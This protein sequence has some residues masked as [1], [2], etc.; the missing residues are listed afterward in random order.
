[1][2]ITRPNIFFLCMH[3]AASTF[4]ADVLLNSI[5]RRTASYDLFHVG[6]FLIR[7]VKRQQEES[8]MI[9][10]RNPEER[11]QQL[12]MFLEDQPLPESNGL[13]GRLYPGHMPTIDKFVSDGIP[14][15]G[16]KLMIMRRDPRDALV[17]LYYSMSISHNPDEVEGDNKAFL[18]NRQTLQHQDVRDGLKTLLTKR[19]IDSTTPEFL[20]CTDLILSNDFVVDLPYEMLINDPYMWLARFVEGADIEDIVDDEWMEQ[21]VGNLQPPAKEDPTSHKRRMRPGN[22]ADV[23][24]E[25]LKQIVNDKLGNRL[26]QFGYKW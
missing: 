11:R 5:A 2:V 25:E 4:V 12:E 23:F 17:S 10:A 14:S 24:D 6:S 15:E 16:N 26:E 18:K 7:Y 9:P 8:G 13:I 1:M 21:M 22:W 20:H 3:K 19:G